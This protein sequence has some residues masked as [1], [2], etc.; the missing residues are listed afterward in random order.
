[1]AELLNYAL[2][3]LADVK[4]SLGMDSGNTSNDNLIIRKINQATEMIE[5]YC[6]GRRFKS[7]TY[8]DEEYDATNSDQLVLRQR[9]VSVLTS[10]SYRESSDNINSWE[11]INNDYYFLDSDA[12]VVDL[13]FNAVGRWNRYKATYTAGYTTIPADLAEACATLAAYMVENGSGGTGIKKK[14]EG[15]RSVEYF[16]LSLTQS[17][18]LIEQLNLDDILDTYSNYPLQEK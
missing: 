14:Q 6:G 16:N 18:S 4:E 9:P 15:S 13:T 2:T 17:G 12:G 5:R 1:V 7:T 11:V 8:T 3:S 10:L